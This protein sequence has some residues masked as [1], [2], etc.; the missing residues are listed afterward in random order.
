MT[1]IVAVE[2]DGK[3]VMGGDSAGVGGLNV[4]VRADEKV[5]RNGKFLMGFTDSFRMGQLL[6]YSL[7]TSKLKVPDYDDELMKF[8]SVDFINA[9]RKTF[10]DG[11]Y[12]K[13][14]DGDNE[15]GT[16]LVGVKGKIFTI[17]SDFQV[18]RPADGFAAV[19]CGQSYALGA[20]YVTSPSGGV[21]GARHQVRTALETAEKFSGGV[22]APFVILEN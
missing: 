2:S 14:G 1:C 8:M 15:G 19:G 16:F 22:S 17:Y 7:E 13:H 6:R 20:L 10:K 12:G 5:F 18:A 3:V 11:G 4:I 21:D 9:V